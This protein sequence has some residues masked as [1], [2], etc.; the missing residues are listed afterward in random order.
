MSKVIIRPKGKTFASGL[1]YAYSTKFPEGLE[2]KISEEVYLTMI[3]EIND[4]I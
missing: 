2:D 4:T 3:Y 1:A